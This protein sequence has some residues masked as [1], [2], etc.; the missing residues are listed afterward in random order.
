[1]I[2]LSYLM[3][4]RFIPP[5]PNFIGHGQKR[6]KMYLLNEGVD[7]FSYFPPIFHP[8]SCRTRSEQV[9]NVPFWKLV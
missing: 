8:Q 4:F 1:M 3:V 9:K 6:K 7:D 2:F 5:L